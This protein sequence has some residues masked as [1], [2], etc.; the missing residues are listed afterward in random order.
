MKSKHQSA[1]HFFSVL[2]RCL[3]GHLLEFVA[4]VGLGGET[5]I[6]SQL[7]KRPITGEQPGFGSADPAL[8]NIPCRG[9]GEEVGKYAVK[10]GWA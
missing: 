9:L 5:A 1:K 6:Q 8:Q 3:A 4:E 10:I 2:Q 7:C